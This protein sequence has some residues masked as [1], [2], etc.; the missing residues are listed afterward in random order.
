MLVYS[1][2][3]YALTSREYNKAVKSYRGFVSIEKETAEKPAPPNAPVFLLSESGNQANYDNYFDYSTYHQ[4]NITESDIDNILKLPYIS[5]VS[6]RY[7]TAGVAE[8]YNRIYKTGEDDN[9]NYFDLTARYVVEATF[10]ALFESNFLRMDNYNPGIKLQSM[11]LKDVKL[12]AGDPIWLELPDAALQ[13]GGLDINLYITLPDFY[14]KGKFIVQLT[15]IGRPALFYRNNHIYS[16]DLEK[17]IPGE[18][19]VFIGRVEPYM[20]RYPTELIYSFYMGDDTLYNWWPYIYPLEGKADNY[21]DTEEF[22]PL[23]ELIQVTN[24]DL[25]TFDVIYTDD[26]ECIRRVA[27]E[28]ILLTEGRLLNQADSLNKNKVCVVS[29]VFMKENDLK[30]G[31]KIKLKLGDK[32]FE[33]Y[34]PVGAVASLRDR[35]AD[36]FVDAEFEIVGAY[37]DLN[38]DKMRE[39]DL[40][41]AYND[42]SVFVPLSFLPETA[43]IENHELKPAEISF[44]VGD[45]RNIRAFQEVC[46]PQIEAMGYTVYYNDGGWIRLEEQFTQVKTLSLSKLLAFSAATILAGALVVYLFIGRKRREYAVM[47]ALGTTK[48]KASRTLFIPFMLLSLVAVIIGGLASVA[49]AGQTADKTLKTFAEMGLEVNPDVPAYVLILG[50]LALLAFVALLSQIVLSRLGKKPPLMLLQENTNRNNK[51]RKAKEKEAIPEPKK[52]TVTIYN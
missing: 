46:L 37:V 12:L 38:I 31:D 19:Y 45:A 24:D 4:K 40:Y 3:D 11:H 52:I 35:Y 51:S 27:E 34:A 14:E 28:R 29:D 1:A 16:E 33:Q 13:S 10:D 20:Y 32:L 23:R 39:V 26:M 18:R 47:R 15:S 9:K 48:K 43:D 22:A 6:C 21:L 49:Y 41:W 2:A 44:I 42:Y 5:S 25:H 7:M 36:N 17:L 50:M 30:L 8:G